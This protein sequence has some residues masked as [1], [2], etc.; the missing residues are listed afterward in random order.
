MRVRVLF[1]GV[2]KDLTGKPSDSLN[3]PEDATLGDVLSHYQQ[4]IPQLKDTASSLAMSV[5]QE[6]AGPTHKAEVRR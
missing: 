5:N 2:L 4:V 1:F 3:L 6:Y